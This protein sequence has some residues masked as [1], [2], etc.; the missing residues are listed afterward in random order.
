MN[1]LIADD[2]VV[3]RR[4]L[5]AQLQKW[6][7]E[8]AAAPDGEEAWRRFEAG[9]FPLVLT[10]WMMP[11]LDG[12]EL[13]R[14]IRGAGRPGYVYVILL[15][16]RSQKADVVEGMEAGADD[17]LTKPFDPDELRVRVRA[18]ERVV[19][20]E[21]HLGRT[22]AALAQAEKLAG[23]GRL[24][25]GV[26]HEVNNPLAFVTN[27]LTVLRRDVSAA[28]RL[29]E[30][31]RAG[32]E[33][34]ARSEPDRAAEAARLEEEMDVAYVRGNLGRV[35]DRSLAGLQRVRDIV[36][37]LRDFAR[38]DEGELKEADLNAGL[39][40][41]A[42]ILR[43]EFEKRQVTLR[44]CPG[45]L[46]AVRCHPGKVNQ[47]FLNVLLNA[48]QACAPGGVVQARTRPDA[49]GA[50]VVEVEDDGAG[51]RPEHLPRVFEPFFTTKP[52]GQGTG[53]GLAVSYGVVRDHGGTITAE[54]ESGRGSLFRIR[55]PVAGPAAVA[56]PAGPV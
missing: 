25:A 32:R 40:A 43:H 44:L 46:P 28:L 18:G 35:L 45:E 12:L 26:A 48:A 14:R 7:Y 23:L 50:V 8:V 22:R 29:L 49:P 4:L 20:L 31:Y 47:V 16:A 1:V 55:L 52:V 53:L 10:D 33:G 13:V 27:N 6:G 56:A 3:S 51:I 37:N 17:F 34:L 36:A 2:D 30:V 42:E 24:A 19:R 15:T 54:S 11:G 21:H 9:D 41:T 39:A 38:L 5:Q